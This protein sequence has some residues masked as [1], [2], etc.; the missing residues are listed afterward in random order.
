M[1]GLLTRETATIELQRAIEPEL[2]ADSG[3]FLLAKPELATT[4][5]L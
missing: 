3:K 4:L 2:T 5:G 1:K